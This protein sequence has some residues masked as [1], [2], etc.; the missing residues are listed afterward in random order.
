MNIKKETTIEGKQHIK[1]R[2]KSNTNFSHDGKSEKTMK[3][4]K[5][6]TEKVQM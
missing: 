2:T 5:G 6:K 4:K 1:K 3:K